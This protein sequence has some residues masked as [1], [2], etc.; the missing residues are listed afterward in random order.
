MILSGR[1]MDNTIDFL[2]FKDV[3][4]FGLCMAGGIKKRSIR[5]FIGHFT[6]KIVG[7]FIRGIDKWLALLVPRHF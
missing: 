6:D 2:V 1:H 5:L 3:R 4:L 7:R